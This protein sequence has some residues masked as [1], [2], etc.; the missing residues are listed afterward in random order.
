MKINISFRE[1]NSPTSPRHGIS[2]GFTG[3]NL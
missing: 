1:K 2:R 3:L